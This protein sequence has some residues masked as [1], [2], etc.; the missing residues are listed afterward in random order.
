MTSIDSAAY[1]E[2]VAKAASAAAH[3]AG[4]GHVDRTLGLIERRLAEDDH[5]W[6]DLR[7]PPASFVR[8]LLPVGTLSAIGGP[9]QLYATP[10]SA[11]AP[12]RDR[13]PISENPRSGCPDGFEPRLGV[14]H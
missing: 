5:A 1:R 9:W 14:Y 7:A 2:E 8:T 6:P 13:P 10:P 11:T 4:F 12:P 3:S